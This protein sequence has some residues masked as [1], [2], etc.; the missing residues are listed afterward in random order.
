MKTN[1]EI[2]AEAASQG[3]KVTPLSVDEVSEE[4]V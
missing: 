2:A 4:A 3:D 1:A